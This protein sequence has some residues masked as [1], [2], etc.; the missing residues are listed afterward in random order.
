MLETYLMFIEKQLENM[1]LTGA[2]ATK[3]RLAAFFFLNVVVKFH[4]GNIL[5]FILSCQ[6]HALMI[7]LS[8]LNQNMNLEFEAS[9]VQF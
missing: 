6:S 7:S 8:A 2:H 4:H 3:P 5:I 1:K 9:I